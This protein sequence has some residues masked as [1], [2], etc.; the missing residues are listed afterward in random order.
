MIKISLRDGLRNVRT[1]CCH[2]SERKKVKK[3][4]GRHFIEGFYCIVEVFYKF[5]SGKL[6]DGHK[7][8][9]E[10]FYY[11]RIVLITDAQTSKK[12]HVL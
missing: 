8:K 10:S 2:E 6:K 4:T 11:P 12:G 7:D 3:K 5:R 1:L 9:A